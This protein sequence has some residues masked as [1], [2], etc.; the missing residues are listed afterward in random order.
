MTGFRDL[1]ADQMLVRNDVLSKIM[2]VYERYGFTPLKTP[3]LE[4]YETLNG[5]YGD[6][7]N[8]LMYHF[9]D[10]GGREVALRYDHTVPLARVAAHLGTNL[11][12]PYKRY[13]IGEVWRGES[14][15]AGRYREFT[16][17]DADI[18][19]SDSYLADTEIL[20]MMSDAMQAIGVKAVIRVN[21]RRILDGLAETCAITD[22]KAFLQLVGTID[23]VD[24]IG[25]PAVVKEVTDVFGDEA[26]ANVE[27]YLK[28]NGNSTEKLAAVND[29]LKNDKAIAGIENLQQIFAILNKSGYES[30]VTFDQTIARGLNYYTSTVYETNLVD[31]PSIGSVC[32][33]GRYDQL[34]EQLGGP[35]LPAVG[36][37]VGV[38]RLLEGMRQL[39]LLPELKTRTRAFIANLGADMDATRFTLL[40]QLRHA[41]IPAEMQYD[42]KRLGKQ[43]AA[44]EKMGVSKVIIFGANEAARNVVLLKDL[45]NGE[46]TE[47]LIDDL[48]DRL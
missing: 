21:D 28:L 34:I 15:Q 20:A 5:K 46:Q 18:I 30:T 9:K 17:F 1:M 12:N 3:A 37:S 43:L 16:Q 29:L 10:N 24:K 48:A 4:R 7:G 2:D 39:Q 33:G 42:E 47:T 6:E 23:K 14:P 27:A 41:G 38:D 40:Q 22:S 26:A 45:T 25:V 44:A 8:Q 35:D 32:S 11:P 13:A 19:G 31:L 36:T